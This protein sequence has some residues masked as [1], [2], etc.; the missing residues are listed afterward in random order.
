M[1]WD[2]A[3]LLLH[4]VTLLSGRAHTRVELE[5]K[6]LTVV[7]RR[8]GAPGDARA[9]V[10]SVA[11]ELEARGLLDDAAYARWHASQR[12]SVAGARRPRSRAQLAGELYAKG[13][14]ASLVR[15]IV[16]GHSELASCAAAAL[17]RPALRSAQLVAHL[18][19]KG[20]SFGVVAR[21]ARAHGEG[22]GTLR[23]LVE[24]ER[25]RRADAAAEG[26]KEAPLQ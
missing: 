10:A 14:A 24:E 18:K 23:A 16:A 25:D 7:L 26:G 9:M 13:V 17:R 8:A 1:S 6:L 22:E 3:S 12:D 19:F 5:R 2:K 4:G 11:T 20:F 21:V 15:E